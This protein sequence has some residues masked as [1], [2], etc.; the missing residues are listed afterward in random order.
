MFSELIAVHATVRLNSLRTMRRLNAELAE[1]TEECN[2]ED[3]KTRRVTLASSCLPSFV[4][5]FNNVK[6]FS[7]ASAVSALNVMLF[8][9][10][11][12]GHYVRCP[13]LAGLSASSLS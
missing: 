12:R 13:A 4:V 2:H 10:S 8:A 5:T 7:A 3:T 6:N 11:E 1:L 9:I